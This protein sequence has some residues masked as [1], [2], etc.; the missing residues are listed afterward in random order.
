MHSVAW[1]P[2][3]HLMK[4]REEWRF[5]RPTD[6]RGP[7]A[8]DRCCGVSQSPASQSFE[9][10]LGFGRQFEPHAMWRSQGFGMKCSSQA[11]Q[12][13]CC[14]TKSL[15]STC[16]YVLLGDPVSAQS[17]REGCAPR[18]LIFHGGQGRQR[19]ERLLL[20]LR[21]PGSHDWSQARASHQGQ[22]VV[23]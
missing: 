16:G 18:Q 5:I 22:A 14:S 7:A 6:C 12:N 19:Y 10:S 23:D 20:A 15:A 9:R 2:L 8:A 4:R 1:L 17:L 21:H 3:K 13:H 11:A